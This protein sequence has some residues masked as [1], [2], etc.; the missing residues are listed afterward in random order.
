M[1]DQESLL[2]DG[3][4]GYALEG[5]YVVPRHLQSLQGGETGSHP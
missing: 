5:G 1:V 2:L 3:S 4:V